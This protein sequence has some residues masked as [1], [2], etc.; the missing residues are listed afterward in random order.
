MAAKTKIKL[1]YKARGS[2]PEGLCKDWEGTIMVPH[3]TLALGVV[4]QKILAFDIK[5]LYYI[6]LYGFDTQ[7][8]EMDRVPLIWQSYDDDNKPLPPHGIIVPD[9]EPIIIPRENFASKNR[10]TIAERNPLLVKGMNDFSGCYGDYELEDSYAYEAPKK[11]VMNIYDDADWCED[12]D[13]PS[14]FVSLTPKEHKH[15]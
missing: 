10:S 2:N 12:F 5:E 8:G 14:N 9:K 3:M 15:E 11:N 7:T 6:A 1:W 4:R 13:V